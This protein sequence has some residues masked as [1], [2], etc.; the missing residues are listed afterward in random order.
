M[1]ST[2]GY[3]GSLQKCLLSH[4]SLSE[5]LVNWGGSRQLNTCQCGAY[6][7][8]SW[9]EDLGNYNPVSLTS[10]SGKVMEQNILSMIT[11]HMWDNQGTRPS[12]HGFMK[13]WS[14]L[15]NLI[16]FYDEVTCLVHE[17]KAVG[18]VYLDFSKACLPQYPP[19][20]CGS[21]W[22]KQVAGPCPESCGEW[23]QIQLVISH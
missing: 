17:R 9:K 8:K 21:P 20:E 22:L 14:Y 2:Q 23:S 4:I 16:S 11:W 5:F 10:V 7:Q 12:Q 18:V 13:N 19:R 3:R 15:T 1:G 6:L